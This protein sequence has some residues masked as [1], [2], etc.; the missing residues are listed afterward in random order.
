MSTLFPKLISYESSITGAYVDGTWVEGT[1]D[2]KTF[3]GGVQPASGK[4]IESLSTGRRDKGIVKV[5]STIE[6]AVSEESGNTSGDIVHYRG[7]RWELIYE[8]GFQNG[9][10]PHFKYMAQYIGVVE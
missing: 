5:Y 2:I 8:G 7:K 4:D 6:L 9:L 3:L 10:I 1:K